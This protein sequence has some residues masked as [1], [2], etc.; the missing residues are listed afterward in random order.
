MLRN[1][2]YE[3]IIWA[4]NFIQELDDI[5][6]DTCPGGS[7]SWTSAVA[8]GQRMPGEVFAAWPQFNWG[9][10]MALLTALVTGSSSE[11]AGN[12]LM[13]ATKFCMDLTMEIGLQSIS[14]V[15][16]VVWMVKRITT[17]TT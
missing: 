8:A 6:D 11:A 2:I 1:K 12:F 7:F 9:E 13:P 10:K 5:P 14:M 16:P 3:N 17:Q 15:G 4:K